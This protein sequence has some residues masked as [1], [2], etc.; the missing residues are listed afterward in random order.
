[1]QVNRIG[2]QMAKTNSARYGKASAKSLNYFLK[3]TTSVQIPA[4]LS[5]WDSGQEAVL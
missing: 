4:T 1:M 2:E 3:I 5:M